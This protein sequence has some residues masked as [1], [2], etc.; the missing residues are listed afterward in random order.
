MK[1]ST[2]SKISTL[3]PVSKISGIALFLLSN[4]V[5]A[6]SYQSFSTLNYSQNSSTVNQPEF[7]YFQ[8]GTSEQRTYPANQSKWDYDS[9]ALFSQY[10]FEEQ[11]A[12][13]P[14]NEFDYINTSSTIYALVSK[15]VLIFLQAT[16]AI[17]L[18]IVVIMR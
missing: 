13:G 2:F 6:E 12:L 4:T 7:I 8:N 16:L 9:L 5:L 18:G 17:L 10:Y 1:P 15:T 14:L 11:Q 3:S